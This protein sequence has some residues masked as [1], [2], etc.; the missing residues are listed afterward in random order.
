MRPGRRSPARRVV[1]VGDAFA[2]LARH[3]ADSAARL[4]AA[5]ACPIGLRRLKLAGGGSNC[6]DPRKTTC[7]YSNPDLRDP[8]GLQRHS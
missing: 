7:R 6:A 3:P 4:W 8:G 2:G 1:A 5:L